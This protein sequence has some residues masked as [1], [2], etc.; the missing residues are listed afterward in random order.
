MWNEGILYR[1]VKYQKGKERGGVSRGGVRQ[2]RID[3]R[4]NF[5]KEG[6]V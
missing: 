5:G 6:K 4:W 3:E 2:G 1:K